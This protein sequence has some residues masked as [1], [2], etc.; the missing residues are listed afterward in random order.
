M[1]DGNGGDTGENKASLNADVDR[2]LPFLEF[3]RR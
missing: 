3:P 2:D 1:V